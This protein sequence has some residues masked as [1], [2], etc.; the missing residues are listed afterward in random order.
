[1][2]KSLDPALIEAFAINEEG[3][4]VVDGK[5]KVRHANPQAEHLWRASPAGLCGR[6]FSNLFRFLEGEGWE[7]LPLL[8]ESFLEAGWPDSEERFEQRALLEDGSLI[9]VEVR[10]ALLEKVHPPL[11]LAVIKDLRVEKQREERLTL[12]SSAVEQ[13]PAG[14]LISDLEGVVEFVNDGFTHLTGISPEQLKGRNFLAPGSA[15]E[16]FSRDPVLCSRIRL[17]RSWRG[18]VR[19]K[20][21]VGGRFAAMVTISP[22][23]GSRGEPIRLLGRFQDTTETV[24]DKEAL[25]VSEQRFSAVAQLVGEWLWEQNPEGFFTYSSEAVEDVLGYRPEEIVGRHYQELMTEADRALWSRMLPPA[26]R[27]QRPFH[28]LINHYAH[29]DGHEVFTESSGMPVHDKEGTLVAWRGVDRDITERKHQEDQLRLRDRAIEAA[30]V[31]IAIARVQAQDYPILYGNPALSR[32]TGYPLEELLGRNLRLL[33]GASTDEKDREVIRKALACGVGCEV[34]LRNYRKDGQPFWNELQLSPVHDDAGAATHYIG[35]ITD[36]TERL[37]AEGARHQ[38]NVAREIQLSLLPKK[39]LIREDLVAAGI[40]IAASQVGGDYYDIIPHGDFVDLVVAD[41]S[42]HSV[43]AAL[44]MTEMR[45][46]LKAELRR[47]DPASQGV[48]E[49]LTVL[50]DL[51]FEDLDGADLFITMF[52]MRYQSSTRTLW[53]SSAGH[54][55][56]LLLRKNAESCELL[57]TDGM[58]L[59]VNPSVRFEEKSLRLDEGD[60]LLL[61]TDGA[62][63][64]Q[65]PEG[66]FFGQES[67]CEA[68]LALREKHAEATLE[69]LLDRLRDFGSDA[70]FVDDVT[71]AVFLV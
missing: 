47:T 26:S 66:V 23:L 6:V 10:F 15:V 39:P 19:G 18:E 45:S 65:N 13:A 9:P 16:A 70:H 71:L 29:R 64:T 21:S 46:T 33:Q 34:I 60:R 11:R 62:V 68:F 31:G 44:I 3:I 28:R 5:G 42:G 57:D 20:S 17:S 32:I 27:I 25:K 30:S 56:P 54:N 12:L 36:V 37:R 43:G 38:L 40:C 14:I 2:V 48:C 53:Y 7:P 61:Y 67:L 35:I 58:I 8:I 55:P 69:N 4:L 22:I 63:E 50:N 1:M 59:G 52:Y 51:L 24:Q 41:V 49:L